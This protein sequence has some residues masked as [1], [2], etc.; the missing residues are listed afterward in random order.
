ME[1]AAQR[2]VTLAHI[3]LDLIDPP[4]TN[5]RA[6]AGDVED[7][8][9]SIRVHGLITPLRLRPV[10]GGRYEVVAG[11]RRWRAARLAGLVEVPAAIDVELGEVARLSAQL[12]ENTD[13]LDLSQL[14]RIQAVQQLL[15][16]G[17]SD[18]EVAVRTGVE[19]EQL[20]VLHRMAALPDDARRLI[21]EGALSIEDAA[22]L[23]Q[24]DDAEVVAQAL[25]D[26]ADGHHPR[27]AIDRAPEK[28]RR[29]RIES[30]ARAKLEKQRVRIIDPPTGY[31]FAASSTTRQIG[32]GSRALHVDLKQHRKEPCHAAYLSPWARSAKD[33]VVYVCTDVRRH[34]AD[35]AAGVEPHLRLA[36]EQ[37][38]QERAA[39]R[40]R[41]KEWRQSHTARREAAMRV[42][43][44]FDQDEG[45]T[46]LVEEVVREHVGMREVAGMALTLLGIEGVDEFD[47]ASEVHRLARTGHPCS[48]LRVAVAVVMGRAEV[49]FAK[50]HGD[51][52]ERENVRAHFRQLAAHGHQLSG[53]ELGQLAEPFGIDSLEERAPLHPWRSLS[54]ATD[55]DDVDGV[56][57]DDPC[58]EAEPDGSAEVGLDA[59]EL[60]EE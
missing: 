34:A 7:L 43:S 60:D 20:S 18:E 31:D 15:E 35:E 1:S 29:H 38:K 12:A 47:A 37:A 51:H 40:A 42:L 36:P 21:D 41:K 25:A 32:A 49:A 3:P 59:A 26:I 50:E 39:K 45:T 57:A 27:S 24:L 9:R 14:E 2:P 11:E 10:G 46:R 13:R 16:L 5:C 56:A 30:Q 4:P 19:P 53:G 17:V 22:I 54:G 8:V 6:V 44:D 23:A 55:Q 58:A 52:R 33:A 48:R 28:V